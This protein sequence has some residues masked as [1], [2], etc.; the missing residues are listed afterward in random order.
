MC[1][2]IRYILDK[3]VK[4]YCDKGNKELNKNG[5][6]CSQNTKSPYVGVLIGCDGDEL[7][8]CEGE[9][10]DTSWLAGV[11]CPIFV[12]FH[13]MEPRLVLVERL[14]NHHLESRAKTRVRNS[15]A[16]F[17]TGEQCKC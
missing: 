16:K 2:R 13:H 7:R 3:I 4:A 14:K 15:A 8:L 17:G 9:S 6:C 11:L 12:H 5:A 10:L 1:K